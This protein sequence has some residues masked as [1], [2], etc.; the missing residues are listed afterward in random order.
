MAAW[1]VREHGVGWQALTVSAKT[2]SLPSANRLNSFSSTESPNQSFTR[3]CT[4]I[5][6]LGTPSI[7]Y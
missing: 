7:G 1:R 2:E 5:R 6:A 4:G 3:I